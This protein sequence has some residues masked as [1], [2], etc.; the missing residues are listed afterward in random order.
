MHQFCGNSGVFCLHLVVPT[1]SLLVEV[2]SICWRIT[3]INSSKKVEGD[4]CVF[5]HI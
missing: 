4:S 3:N 5:C 2:S 1:N